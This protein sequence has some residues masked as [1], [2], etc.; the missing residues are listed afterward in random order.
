MEFVDAFSHCGLSKYKPFPDLQNAMKLAGVTRAVL[1]QHYGEYDN[2]YIG[3]IASADPNRF[4]G[5][6]L[7]DYRKED[8]LADVKRLAGTGQFGGVRLHMDSLE[9]NEELW[10]EACRCSLNIVT[11]DTDG[12]VRRLALLKAFLERNPTSVVILAHMGYPKVDEAPAFTKYRSIFELKQY[13]N[14]Y[15]QVSGMRMFCSYPYRPLW[16]IVDQALESFGPDRML[17]GGNY[18]V[19]DEEKGYVQEAEF[20]RKGGLPIPAD[21][22]STVTCG[23]ALRVWFGGAIRCDPRSA[24]PITDLS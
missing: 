18:P 6:C 14:V 10:Q 24:R 12:V 2:D 9:A 8:A 13:P 21:V 19:V 5:V 20:V 15:F 17:W 11:D 16:P 22:L 3:G 4:T 7:V 1:V 23:T